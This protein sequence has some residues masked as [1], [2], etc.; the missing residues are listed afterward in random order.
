MYLRLAKAVYHFKALDYSTDYLP[1][2]LQKMTKVSRMI[3]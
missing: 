3:A 2:Y 1:Y